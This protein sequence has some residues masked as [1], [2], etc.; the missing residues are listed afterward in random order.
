MNM[1]NGEDQIRNFT[2]QEDADDQELVHLGSVLRLLVRHP[3]LLLHAHLL[4]LHNNRE[5]RMKRHH[6]TKYRTHLNKLD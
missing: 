2:S 4:A 5:H 6:R 1:L 3:D